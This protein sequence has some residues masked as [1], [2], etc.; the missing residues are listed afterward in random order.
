MVSL[1]IVPVFYSLWEDLGEILRRVAGRLKKGV[2]VAT[3]LIGTL[4]RQLQIAHERIREL[5]QGRRPM[6]WA[7][8]DGL[9]QVYLETRA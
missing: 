8:L 6:S 3:A 2:A 7:N 5:E 4:T 1:L 9:N